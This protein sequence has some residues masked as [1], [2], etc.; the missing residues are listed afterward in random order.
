MGSPKDSGTT[1][2]VFP[3]NNLPNELLLNIIANVDPH[4][5]NRVLGHIP[6][7]P[8]PSQPD[9][10][11]IRDFLMACRPLWSLSLT[12][13][14]FRKLAQNRLYTAPV[15]SGFAFRF[16]FHKTHARIAFFLRTL[17]ARPDLRKHV[18]HIRLCYPNSGEP[19]VQREE[20]EESNL[21]AEAIPFVTEIVDQCRSLIATFDL[22]A[23][24]K[25]SWI[26]QMIVDYRY[27]LT[28][29]LLAL[30]PKLETLSFS[31]GDLKTW[32]YL[33]DHVLNVIGMHPYSHAN[34][35]LRSIKCMPAAQSLRY[36]KLSSLTPIRLDGLDMFENLDSL[37][38][39]IK[40]AG[41]DTDDIEH[42]SRLYSGREA[43][44]NFR[45]LRNLRFDCQIKSV[46]IWDFSARS[47][48]LHIL[49]AFP[50]ITSLDFYAEPS[51]EKNPFKSVRAFPHYQANIQAYP[52]TP[53]IADYDASARDTFW[54]ERVYA[55][56]TDWT[57]YQFLVDSLHHI[58]PRLETLKLPGGFWT[59]PGAA[60]KPIPRFDK[61]SR[62]KTLVVPQ[63]AVLSIKLYNMRFPDT[64]DG[65]FELLPS[66]VFP[67]TLKRL[68]IFDADAD[69][70]DSR[71]LE[72]LLTGH[73]AESHEFELEHLEILFGPMFD[74]A[75][76]E[77]IQAKTA[78][79]P[80]WTMVDQATFQ[81]IVGRDEMVPAAA[82]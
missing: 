27:T 39:S 61:F 20:N 62:L 36:L 48:M 38:I 53:S 30:L 63:A 45:N 5:Y 50:A 51:S 43:L 40:L 70:L 47:G 55:A 68:K 1:D 21:N 64:T 33:D 12:S 35:D 74:D 6:D 58:R 54:D 24:M 44:R 2:Y 72:E 75:E 71:W 11:L 80:F 4:R 7:D 49:Q 81:V 25:M 42:L 52:A 37:D 15:L 17:F 9:P 60:R 18:R 13:R 76:L 14:K 66:L 34:I 10:Y 57:D 32:L 77:K 41:L 26:G 59:L 82:E 19:T 67:P 46:G 56:R 3:L 69:L 65:D 22:P 79:S 31:E 28:G 16:S 78:Y 29:V 8:P 73:G 23:D